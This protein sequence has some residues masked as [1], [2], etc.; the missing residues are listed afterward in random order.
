MGPWPTARRAGSRARRA[1]AVSRAVG[2]CQVAMTGNGKSGLALALVA[3]PPIVE[4]A[5]PAIS[6]LSR[7]SRKATWPG[8]WPGAAMTSSEPTRSPGLSVRVGRGLGAGVGA[9]HLGLGRLAGVGGLVLRQQP[10]VALG[11]RDLDAR[12]G[13]GERVERADVVAVGVGQRD[14]HDRAAELLGRGLDRLGAAGE[15]GVDQRQPVLLLHEV[16]VDEAEARDAGEAHAFSSRATH[17][18][19]GVWGNMSTGW[20][21]LRTQPASTSCAALGASVVGLQET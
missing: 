6:V 3:T 13:L 10:R 12:E 20:T 1:R 4:K 5:S 9:A 2:L 11:D 21:V 19:C 14:P 17:S 7:V 18:M 16:G 15:R 8:V